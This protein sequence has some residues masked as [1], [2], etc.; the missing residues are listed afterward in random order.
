MV[1]GVTAPRNT[2]RVDSGLN[3]LLNDHLSLFGDFGGE[4]F[5]GACANQGSGG[6]NVNW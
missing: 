1:D 6:V 2:L 5:S 4:Y 3:L